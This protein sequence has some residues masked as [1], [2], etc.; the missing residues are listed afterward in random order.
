MKQLQRLLSNPEGVHPPVGRYSHLARVKAGELLFLAGQVAVDENG[1]LVGKGDVG[2]QTRQTFQ[3]IG[4]ILE[5]AGATFGNVVQVTTYLV[6]R[7]SVQLYLD[8]RTAIFDKAY[9]T[10]EH[11]PNTLLVISGLFDEEMLIEVAIV[12]AL[13]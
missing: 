8:A 12:A 11:P 10:G 9:P 5:S 4:T 2:A 7:E 13:P 3:N 1:D 6:G